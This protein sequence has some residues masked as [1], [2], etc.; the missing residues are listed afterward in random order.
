MRVYTSGNSKEKKRKNEHVWDQV[1]PN[2]SKS[3]VFMYWITNCH[4][5]LTYFFIL[6]I[7]KHLRNHELEYAGA[8]LY[9]ISKMLHCTFEASCVSIKL[10]RD[11]SKKTDSFSISKRR[12]TFSFKH[13][14]SIF[15]F[16]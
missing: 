6:C 10:N 15:S 7:R 3:W 13:S 11:A 9:E 4:V 5:K 2:E 14:P 16:F 8:K 12:A 1:A